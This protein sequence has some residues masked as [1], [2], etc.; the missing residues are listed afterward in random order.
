[1]DKRK[2]AIIMTILT[3]PVWV[4]CIVLLAGCYIVAGV[5][6]V[7]R[8]I[9]AMNADQ[10][11]QAAILTVMLISTIAAICTQEVTTAP[12]PTDKKCMDVLTEWQCNVYSLWITIQLLTGILTGWVLVSLIII[13]KMIYIIWRHYRWTRY[14]RRSA[15]STEI[16]LQRTAH[17]IDPNLAQH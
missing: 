8:R 5:I 6:I 2:L 16:G 14:A 13:W 3:P 17:Q 15:E 7:H 9:K 12:P 10:W 4:G 11:I 1:M